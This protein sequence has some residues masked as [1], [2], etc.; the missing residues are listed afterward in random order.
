[1]LL[2]DL[3]HPDQDH[4]WLWDCGPP[5][6]TA[7]SRKEFREAVLLRLGGQTVEAGTPC[8]RCGGA[9]DARARHAMRCAPGQSSRRHSRIR[10]T[11]HGLAAMSDGG[12]ITEAAGLLDS[13]PTLRPASLL[14]HA[15][16]WQGKTIAFDVNVASGGARAAGYDPCASAV[17]R[18]HNHHGPFYADMHEAGITYAP[19]CGAPGEGHMWT[20]P[21]LL[22][23]WL[24]QREGEQG[25]T[26]L[27][28]PPQKRLKG[29]LTNLEKSGADGHCVL[30]TG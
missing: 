21:P 17:Q 19:W 10:D 7:L 9:M 3:A 24:D 4:R 6:E 2:E 15:A 27:C 11:L 16:F 26:L 20:P 14:T 13:A 28:Q 1:M 8:A 25:R 12:A 30:P 18:K 29:S 23:Q 22:S 5:S